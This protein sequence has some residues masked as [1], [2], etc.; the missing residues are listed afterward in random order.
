[1]IAD[2]PLFAAAEEREPVIDALDRAF[3]SVPVGSLLTAE[4][5]RGS[6]SFTIREQLAIPTRKNLLGAWFRL[7]LKRGRVAHDGFTEAQRDA[8]RHRP[9]RR[10]RKVA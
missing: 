6:L 2:L 9:I 5:I 4:T 8:A 3:D 1:M 10:W 7:L